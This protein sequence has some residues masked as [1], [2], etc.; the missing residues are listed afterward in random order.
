MNSLSELSAK[1]DSEFLELAKNRK[2]NGS[3]LQFRRSVDNIIAM[4]NEEK[5]L[6][7]TTVKESIMFFNYKDEKELLKAQ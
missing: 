2:Q 1:I 3:T 5:I 4:I 6:L 7:Q